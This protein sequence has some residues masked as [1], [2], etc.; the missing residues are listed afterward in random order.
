MICVIS[1]SMPSAEYYFGDDCSYSLYII[2]CVHLLRE[3]TMRPTWAQLLNL[4]TDRLPLQFECPQFLRGTLVISGTRAP[5]YIALKLRVP[6][7]CTVW[8]RPLAY[9]E[10]V[11]L[12]LMLPV[13]LTVPVLLLKCRMATIGLKTLPRTT[14]LLRRTLIMMAGLRQQ[15]WLFRAELL[16]VTP[17]RDGPCLRNFRIPLNRVMP[18]RGGISVL[19]LAGLPVNAAEAVPVR[20]VSVVMKLLR[21][22]VRVSIWAVVA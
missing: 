22:L 20:L 9:M 1:G 15:F 3:A 21:T 6:V 13:Y 11:R 14:L 5:T 8:L 19:L 10:S 2:V 16:V 12:Q 7:T 17:V 4:H 18:P